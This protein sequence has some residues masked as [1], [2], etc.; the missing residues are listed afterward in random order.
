MNARRVP[1]QRVGGL[2]LAAAMLVGGVAA[3]A[4]RG[5]GPGET[6]RR[7]KVVV[8]VNFGDATRQGN[9]LKNVENILKAAEAVGTAV[10]VEVVCHSDGIALLE[11]TKTAHA[12]TIDLLAKKG[13]HFAACQNTM[14]Q[15]LIRPED[16]LAG[17]TTVPSGAFEVVRRQQDGYSYFK[18]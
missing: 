10:E 1:F 14:R 18:P 11:K 16:L 6:A 9:G 7:L 17:V 4:A 3:L 12:G 5:D 2:A 13:V 8:H 15:R